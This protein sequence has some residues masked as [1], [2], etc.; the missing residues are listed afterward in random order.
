MQGSHLVFFLL[1]FN[2]NFAI[3]D[4]FL[5]FLIFCIFSVLQKTHLMICALLDPRF[6]RLI[7]ITDFD[8]DRCIHI[9]TEK[10]N[11]ISESQGL[12]SISMNPKNP[13]ISTKATSA[14]GRKSSK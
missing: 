2:I 7:A 11:G 10:Y 1:D 3:N 9:L 12:T 5:F 6:H 14:T 4:L 13:V 8:F